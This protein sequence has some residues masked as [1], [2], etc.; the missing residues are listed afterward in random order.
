MNGFQVLNKRLKVQPKKVRDKPYWQCLFTKKSTL[1][2][3]FWWF[4]SCVGVRK[5]PMGGSIHF[6]YWANSRLWGGKYTNQRSVQQSHKPSSKVNPIVVCSICCLKKK[7]KIIF[8][9]Y[10]NSVLFPLQTIMSLYFVFLSLFFFCLFPLLSHI[11]CLPFQTQNCY[12]WIF[13]VVPLTYS[14]IPIFVHALLP[15][16][17]RVFI[18][19]DPSSDPST[20]PHPPNTSATDNKFNME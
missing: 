1:G 20:Q 18:L 11:Y 4:V 9:L 14:P 2:L 12:F 10:V 5:G 16:L 6:L 7:T 3:S 13:N 15:S 8:S 19:I 17:S